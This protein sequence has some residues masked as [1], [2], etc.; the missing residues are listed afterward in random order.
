MFNYRILG[1][2]ALMA[3]ILCMMACDDNEIH[4]AASAMNKVSIAVGEVQKVTISMSDQ[5][6]IPRDTAD[7]IVGV[8]MRASIAGKEID[9][10]LRTIQ[11]LDQTSRKD[12][13]GL[14]QKISADFDPQALEFV[15]GIK[16][17]SAKQK[18]E[19]TLVVM[20]S[21]LASV[22]LIVATGG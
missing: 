8:C 3:M 5:N 21:A 10:I 20:R 7:K 19:G 1:I 22:Q 4:K 13:V 2:A 16:N 12:I 6:L 9:K 15:A 18:I 17:E 11:A 14:L